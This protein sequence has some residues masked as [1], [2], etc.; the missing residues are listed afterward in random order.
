MWYVNG[1]NTGTGKSFEGVDLGL[2]DEVHLEMIPDLGCDASLPVLSN[3]IVPNYLKCGC[4]LSIP[5][6]ISPNGDFINDQWIID[7]IDCWHN[8]VKV[9]NRYGNIVYR[10]KDY[11]N[12][13]DGT[14]NGRLL[15]VATY[16]YVITVNDS[17]LNFETHIGA[18]TIIR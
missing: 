17:D 2:Y 9:Y 4:K 11:K 1:V 8:E 6:G 14:R 12:D 18:V 10:Q 13:W 7:G 5:E 15:P 16:Y 3:A